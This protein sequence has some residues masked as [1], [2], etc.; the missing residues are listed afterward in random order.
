MKLII[1]MA[2]VAM[3]VGNLKSAE[4]FVGKQ[5]NDLNDGLSLE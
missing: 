2:A 1:I 4:Y 3:S 5:G